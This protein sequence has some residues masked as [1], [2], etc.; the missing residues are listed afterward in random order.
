MIPF[1]HDRVE[2]DAQR[3]RA[4]HAGRQKSSPVTTCALPTDV[5][6]A[7]RQLTRGLGQSSCNDVYRAHKALYQIGQPAVERAKSVSA[8]TTAYFS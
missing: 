5:D 4:A 7:F 1:G 3:R 6:T 8:L 2:S